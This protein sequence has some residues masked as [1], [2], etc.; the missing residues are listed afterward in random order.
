MIRSILTHKSRQTRTTQRDHRDRMRATCHR[1]GR[2][3]GG[4]SPLPRRR[5]SSYSSDEIAFVQ[6]LND[7][8]VS[9]GLQP[10]K[11]SDMLSRS[12]RQA[13]FGH[14]QVQVLRP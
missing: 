1:C 12:R 3:L 6:L 8:S 7:Y 2:H 11:V 9:N 13:R 4:C 14:G 5:R 10:L